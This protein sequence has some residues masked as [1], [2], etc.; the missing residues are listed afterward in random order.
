MQVDNLPRG[1]NQPFYKVLVDTRDRNGRQLSYIAE[2]N[3]T[4][5]A[6]ATPGGVQHS[7]LGR[8]GSLFWALRIATNSLGC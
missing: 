3:I 8:C 6:D 5:A 4:A 2:E 1:R 7:E